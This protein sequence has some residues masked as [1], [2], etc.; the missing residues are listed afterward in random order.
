M[1]D[2]VHASAQSSRNSF[3]ADGV[4]GNFLAQ[5]VC[6]LDDGPRFFIG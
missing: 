6:F 2:G 5:P 1:L 3:A 4:G